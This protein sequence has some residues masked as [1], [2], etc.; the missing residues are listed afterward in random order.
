MT[1]GFHDVWISLIVVL[2]APFLHAAQSTITEAEGN[3]CSGDDRFTLEINPP[4][5]EKNI[6]LYA[7]TSPLGDLRLKAAA[8]IY[9]VETKSSDVAARTRGVRIETRP[10]GQ[11]GPPAAGFVEEKVTIR[12][13]R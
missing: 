12:T 13:V 2:T 7:G 6:P 5:G 1:R 8:G 9:E 3:A 4:F 11:A 10:D